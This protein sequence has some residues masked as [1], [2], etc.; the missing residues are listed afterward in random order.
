LRRTVEGVLTAMLVAFFGYLI[1]EKIGIDTGCP[2][3]GQGDEIVA[4]DLFVCEW[5]IGQAEPDGFRG[6]GCGHACDLR[7]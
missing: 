6:T 3:T 1:F 7:Q 5:T 2:L 4:Q